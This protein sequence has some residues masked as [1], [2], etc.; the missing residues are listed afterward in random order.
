[1]CSVFFFIQACSAD[2]GAF[3]KSGR[4]HQSH[5]SSLHVHTLRVFRKEPHMR[6]VKEGDTVFVPN[7]KKQVW[8]NL[9]F[10]ANLKRYQI[11]D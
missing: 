9:F 10:W 3:S 7:L 2:L 8:A 1:M 4:L 5:E 6:T 11:S